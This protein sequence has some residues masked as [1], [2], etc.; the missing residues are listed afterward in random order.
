MIVKGFRGRI[1]VED[2]E[3]LA[4]RGIYV[5]NARV[6]GCREQLIH[7]VQKAREM[8]KRGRNIAKKEH[9]EVML[10][11]TGRRQ[12]SEAIAL[13]GVEGAEEIAAISRDDFDLPLERDDSVLDFREDKL[14][15]LGIKE[16]VKNR[17]CEAF[18]ENSAMLHLHR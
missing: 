16:V 15:Y 7:A 8:M 6:V 17:E 13:A 11:L 14:E 9:I 1:G 10:I 4:S 3:E 2:A 12:I 5:F 18:F